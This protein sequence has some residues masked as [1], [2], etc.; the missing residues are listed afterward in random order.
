MLSFFEIWSCGTVWC[1]PSKDLRSIIRCFTGRFLDSHYHAKFF[2]MDDEDWSDCTDAQADMRLLWVLI[3]E[4]KSSHFAAH[5]LPLPSPTV[6]S[7]MYTPSEVV[8]F[9]IMLSAADVIGT[10]RVMLSI[11][12]T[13][14][15]S[16]SL[17]VTCKSTKYL[18]LLN[19]TVQSIKSLKFPVTV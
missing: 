9:R 13:A 19:Q 8:C 10:F 1:G 16:K 6:L 17:C 4:G 14:T 7:A 5:Y 3:W 18:L 12:F 2:H 11:F 15:S